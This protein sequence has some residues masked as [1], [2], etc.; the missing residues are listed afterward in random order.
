MEVIRGFV[1]YGAGLTGAD[2]NNGVHGS[3]VHFKDGPLT[4]VRDHPYPKF[5]GDLATVIREPAAHEDIVALDC[6]VL[7]ELRVPVWCE[8]H[9]AWNESEDYLLDQRII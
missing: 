3:V 8:E 1:S 7:D 5:E 9:N 4:Y 6:R 2:G